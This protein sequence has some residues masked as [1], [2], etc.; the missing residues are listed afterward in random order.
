MF[1]K[2]S[3]MWI[4]ANNVTRYQSSM[5]RLFQNFYPINLKNEHEQQVKRCQKQEV[6]IQ[7]TLYYFLRADYENAQDLYTYLYTYLDLKILQK[8]CWKWI[9]LTRFLKV[10]NSPNVFF[11]I[12]RV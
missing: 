3:N 7:K 10:F 5:F 11:A 9:F 4:E 12:D 8:Y 2:S 6:R 1:L